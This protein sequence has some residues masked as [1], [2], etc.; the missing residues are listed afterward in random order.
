MSDDWSNYVA[1]AGSDPVALGGATDAM[2]DAIAD[3]Q[4]ALEFD[5]HFFPARGCRRR[6]DGRSGRHNDCRQL[7]QLEPGRSRQRR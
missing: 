1:D 7:G 5:R 4:P 3:A 6:R 2:G